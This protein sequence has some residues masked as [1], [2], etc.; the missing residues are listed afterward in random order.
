MGFIQSEMTHLKE[1]KDAMKVIASIEAM[2][3]IYTY[4][5]KRREAGK[6]SL[7]RIFWQRPDGNE[8][9]FVS[10]RSRQ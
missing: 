2:K 9:H 3:D 5:K 10:F 1:N 4:W 8:T 6:K 7:L